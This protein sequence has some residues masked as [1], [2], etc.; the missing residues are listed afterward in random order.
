MFSPIKKVSPDHALLVNLPIFSRNRFFVEKDWQNLHNFV[1]GG[2]DLSN[3][4]S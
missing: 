4:V 2:R 1:G 3:N